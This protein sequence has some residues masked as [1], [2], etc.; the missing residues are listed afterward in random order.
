MKRVH[1]TSHYG[2]KSVFP[3]AKRSLEASDFEG[4]TLLLYA[5]I[6]GSAPV[7]RA[8]LHAIEV[9]FRAD[10][11]VSSAK[12]AL[13]KVSWRKQNNFQSKET[14]ETIQLHRII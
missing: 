9:A 3:Q 13:Q 8:V 14:C 4:R 2:W 10:E 7:F 5:A 6:S 11:G 12:S 1:Y